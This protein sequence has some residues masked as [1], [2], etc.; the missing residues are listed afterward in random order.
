[1][2]LPLPGPC[3]ECHYGSHTRIDGRH[4]PTCSL[5]NLETARFYAQL[6][7]TRIDKQ[8]QRARAAW[9]QAHLWE[10]KFHILR[11]ENNALR[12]KLYPKNSTPVRIDSD[13]QAYRESVIRHAESLGFTRCEPYAAIG[14]KKPRWFKDG[15]YFDFH[16]LPALPPSS[17]PAASASPSLATP[18]PSP[19][20][21]PE[22]AHTPPNS[23][24]PQSGS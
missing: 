23:P 20:P 11:H 9:Q 6:A 16:E 2:P 10:G 14:S 17:P 19:T 15:S 1:M 12:R 3:P 13:V 22:H 21:P 7:E 18:Y 5:I 8:N 4:A 24:S